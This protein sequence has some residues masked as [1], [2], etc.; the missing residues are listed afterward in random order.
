[1][2]KIAFLTLSLATV[3]LQVFAA[4]AD[5][6]THAKP[7]ENVFQE[8]RVVNV[9]HL[10]EQ[11]LI[12][13]MEGSHPE[14]AVEFSAQT[15]LPVSFFLKGELLQLMET[16]G[17]SEVIEIKQTFYA[18]RVGE[19]LILSSNLIDWKP[20]FEFL[21]GTTSVALSIR[22]GQPSLVIGAEANKRP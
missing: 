15:K 16:E 21:T 4:P 22:E 1:M 18:R 12:E 9:S 3:C 17:K 2:K 20:F 11:E 7:W 8:L 10:S 19:D 14:V 6:S 13:I 5:S